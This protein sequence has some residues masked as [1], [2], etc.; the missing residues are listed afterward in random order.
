MSLMNQRFFQFPTLLKCLD[1][2]METNI[3]LWQFLLELLL[4]HQ[5]KNIITWTNNDGEFKLVNAEEVARL[6][7]LRKNKHNMNYDKLSR[8]LRYYYDKNII[9]KVL[10]QKFVYR[11]VSFPEIVKMENK[12]PFHIKM[13][14]MSGSSPASIDWMRSSPVSGVRTLGSLESSSRHHHS[15]RRDSNNNNHHNLGSDPPS[16]SGSPSNV[17]SNGHHSSSLSHKSRHVDNLN[18]LNHH[19]SQHL[20]G[21]SSPLL[22][23]FGSFNHASFQALLQSTQHSKFLFPGPGGGYNPH[24]H[25]PSLSSSSAE[26]VHSLRHLLSPTAHLS[27]SSPQNRHHQQHNGSEEHPHHH[28]DDH[29]SSPSPSLE[30]TDLSCKSSSSPRSNSSAS[31]SRNAGVNLGNVAKRGFSDTDHENESGCGTDNEIES[32]GGVSSGSSSKRMKIEVTEEEEEVE[33]E[34]DHEQVMVSRSPSPCASIRSIN[35]SSPASSGTGSASDHLSHNMNVEPMNLVHNSRNSNNVSNNVSNGN[36]NETSDNNNN[37]TGSS[38]SVVGTVNNHSNENGREGGKKHLHKKHKPPPITGI[39]TSPS[40]I[41]SSFASSLQTPIVTLASPFTKAAHSLPSAAAAAL[42]AGFWQSPFGLS[43][44]YAASPRDHER[45]VNGAKS[46]SA[47]GP[48]ENGNNSTPTGGSSNYFQFPGGHHG[49]SLPR[50]PTNMNLPFSLS[51]LMAN[52]PYFFDP[53]LLMSPGSGGSSKSTI[54]VHQ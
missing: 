32:D 30:P 6:W 20:Q 37:E 10:G 36:T 52:N 24:H 21:L 22:S 43:P 34:D 29:H 54:P 40:R 7:G 17:P 2:G 28:R 33:V 26:S 50:T 44:R 46:D 27:S 18:L 51:P 23:P 42:F 15:H 1:A 53:S 11:F 39:P 19:L 13:E 9:K 16:G 25:H 49:P 3:T 5:Y 35:T 8:A 47:L 4:N 12:V 48:K 14:S 41:T 45:N 38:S 31:S